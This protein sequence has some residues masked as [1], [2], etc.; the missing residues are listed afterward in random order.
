M[1]S[2]RAPAKAPAVF[3]RSMP[4]TIAALAALVAGVLGLIATGYVAVLFLQTSEYTTNF[5]GPILQSIR[6]KTFPLGIVVIALS[7]LHVFVGFKLW[8]STIRWGVV[9]IMLAAV[10]IALY[11][12]ALFAPILVDALLPLLVVGTIMAIT[13][14][15]GWDTLR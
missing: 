12:L 7:I 1:S 11:S 6:G 15:F 5:I 3:K 8:R 9:G 10:D 4:I 13:I 14:I 2:P